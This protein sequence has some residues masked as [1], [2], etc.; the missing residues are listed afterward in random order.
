[1]PI[2]LIEMYFG[3]RMR[4]QALSGFDGLSPAIALDESILL[5][6]RERGKHLSDSERREF[7]RGWREGLYR[8]ACNE[9][10]GCAD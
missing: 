9:R 5:R 7:V 3:A 2:A 1:M 8:F 10:A 4:H 6:E